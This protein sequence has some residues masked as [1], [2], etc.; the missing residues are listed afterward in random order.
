MNDSTVRTTWDNADSTLWEY[1]NKQTSQTS[2]SLKFQNPSY[3]TNEEAGQMNQAPEAKE[4]A[5]VRSGYS[6]DSE[7]LI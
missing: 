5:S 3:N 6:R 7:E 2:E 4:C 1:S